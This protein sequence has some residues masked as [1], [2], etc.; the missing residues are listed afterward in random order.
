MRHRIPSRDPRS[1]H[2]D[3]RSLAWPAVLLLV[4]C[5]TVTTT[6]H[7]PR[8]GAG[9]DLDHNL[10][11]SPRLEAGYS[12]LSYRDAAGWLAGGGGSYSPLTGWGQLWAEVGGWMF[13]LLPLYQM[14]LTFRL[15][16]AFHPDFEPT[17]AV[18]FGVGGEFYKAPTSCNPPLEGPW[19]GCPPDVWLWTDTVYP[20]WVPQAHYLATMLPL[21]DRRGC[22]D[23]DCPLIIHTLMFDPILALH[24]FTE[25]EP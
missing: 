6:I 5:T 10:D 14:P 3:G 8:F 13:P 20:D 12:Y 1:G 18:S 21:V 7:G 2:P 16:A 9:I 23:G 4:G 19:E 15:G 11:V 24:F 17:L 22:T 25:D